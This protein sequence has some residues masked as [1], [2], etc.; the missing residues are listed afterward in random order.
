MSRDSLMPFVRTMDMVRV[1]GIG[2]SLNFVLRPKSGFRIHLI[3]FQMPYDMRQLSENAEMTMGENKPYLTLK[4]SIQGGYV[5][6]GKILSMFRHDESG[7]CQANIW[8]EFAHLFGV[9]KKI[10]DNQPNPATIVQ[11]MKLN[12]PNV[13]VLLD[14]HLTAINRRN[15]PKMF[16][17]NRIVPSKMTWKYPTLVHSGG[18]QKYDQEDQAPDRKVFF[19]VLVTPICGSVIDPGGDM[20]GVT[21]DR[22]GE[23][24]EDR[25]PPTFQREGSVFSDIFGPVASTSQLETIDEDGPTILA[26]PATRSS[27]KGKEKAVPKA[28]PSKTP[29]TPK[30]VQ[31]DYDQMPDM[32]LSSEA[33]E[34]MNAMVKAL[35]FHQEAVK[36]ERQRKAYDED[37]EPSPKDVDEYGWSKY[38]SIL[39]R[40]T[41]KIWWTPMVYQ[42]FVKTA[43]FHM[44][45]RR[46][47]F[48]CK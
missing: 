14:R 44:K 35:A 8:D 2:Y 12:H 10:Y 7:A 27:T 13:T 34:Q 26:G 45:R 17:I 29:K 42:K 19:M 24:A 36:Y 32:Q 46:S 18:Y 39:F 3:M 30:P 48:R 1:R 16:G 9:Q 43:R 41:F 4:F 22:D 33:Q 31:P 20:Q 47:Y 37:G 11:T 15:K 21:V 38:M 25:P 6:N 40:P 5:L 28:T 23:D